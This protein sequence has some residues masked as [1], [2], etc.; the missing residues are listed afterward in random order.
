MVDMGVISKFRRGIGCSG[1]EEFV[2][3]ESM[4][5]VFFCFDVVW[6]KSSMM[7][8]RVGQKMKM[9]MKMKIKM[10]STG[11]YN[12]REIVGNSDAIGRAPN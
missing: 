7:G 11:D 2:M 9:K 6:M 3:L 4:I 1:C 12:G 8:K 5:W 10:G